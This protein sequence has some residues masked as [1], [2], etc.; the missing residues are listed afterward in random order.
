MTWT[1]VWVVVGWSLWNSKLLITLWRKMLSVWKLWE[2]WPLSDRAPILQPLPLGRPMADDDFKW[3]V[4]PFTYRQQKTRYALG[5]FLHP[6]GLEKPLALSSDVAVIF[7]PFLRSRAATIGR[8]S[9]TS[10]RSTPM[11]RC[12]LFFILWIFGSEGCPQ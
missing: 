7:V 11:H 6:F 10:I 2:L 1:I 9:S 3:G 4:M 12:T 8:L 5:L